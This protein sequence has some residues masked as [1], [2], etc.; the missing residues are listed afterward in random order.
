MGRIRNIK[1]AIQVLAALGLPRTQQNERSALCLLALLN[2]T[3]DKTWAQAESPLVG[4]TPM[5]DFAREH[6]RKE[7]APNTRETFRRQTMHQFM[8]AGV[9]TYNPDK[10]DR[11]VNS[12]KAVYQILPETLELLKTYGTKQWKQKL[13]TYLD[14]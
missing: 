1:T 14:H 10:S 6:Y 7:Y 13:K 5:M 9:A 3:P 2:L 8:Q 12:P 4:I 11:P